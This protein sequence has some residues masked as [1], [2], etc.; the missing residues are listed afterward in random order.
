LNGSEMVV[1]EII[2]R[3]LEAHLSDAQGRMVARST[4]SARMIQPR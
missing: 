3:F 4:A 2:D 1:G